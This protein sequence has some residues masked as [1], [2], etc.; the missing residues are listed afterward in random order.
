MFGGGSAPASAPPATGNAAPTTDGMVC[1]QCKAPLV[2]GDE[3]CFNCGT[4]VRNL[5]PAPGSGGNGNAPA[6]VVNV[7]S[8]DDGSVIQATP[9]TPPAQQSGGM[10]DADID[11]ELAAMKAQFGGSASPS[12]ASPTDLDPVA[13]SDP[14]TPATDPTPD[15]APATAQIPIQ[16]SNPVS[17]GF[18]AIGAATPSANPFGT[19]SSA[20]TAPP[21]SNVGASGQRSLRLHVAGPYGDEMVEYKGVELL[22]GRRDP[23]TRVFPDVNLDDA[24]ASRRHLAL[25]LDKDDGKFYAQDLESA[26]GTSLNG[27]DLP[28]GEPVAVNNNDVLKIGTRYSIQVRVS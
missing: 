15:P 24:A 4:D 11:R 16:Q 27:Q 2:P 21:M 23:K 25:W 3:F 18:G 13:P 7:Q 9:A 8:P 20:P 28:P 26:N 10:S 17:G 6:P 12:V 1:P 22:L 14:A 19:P 5:A